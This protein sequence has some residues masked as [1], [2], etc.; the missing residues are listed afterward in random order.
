MDASVLLV[1]VLVVVVVVTAK[2]RLVVVVS[3]DAP[4]AKTVDAF[5]FLRVGLIFIIILPVVRFILV[6]VILFVK[7]LLVLP[8]VLPLGS[9][10]ME[11]D[12]DVLVLPVVVVDV[13]TVVVSDR[14]VNASSC[15]VVVALLLLLLD[16]CCCCVT[17]DVMVHTWALC[18]R[19]SYRVES[20]DASCVLRVVMMYSYG[21]RVQIIQY[22]VNGISFIHGNELPVRYSE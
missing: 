20:C 9:P 22:T 2:E 15:T 21:V 8:V 17:D 3:R 7:S 13:V 14:N 11:L 6:P 16:T 4:T 12:M 18:C 19:E 10:P 5:R 1:A